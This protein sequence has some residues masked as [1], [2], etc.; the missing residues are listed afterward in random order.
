MRLDIA[1]T[2]IDR[3]SA[4]RLGSLTKDEIQFIADGMTPD[5]V[6]TFLFAKNVKIFGGINGYANDFFAKG[7]LERIAA[8][9]AG[10]DKEDTKRALREMLERML[11][12]ADL[13]AE[14]RSRIT[15][16]I[17]GVLGAAA[18]AAGGSRHRRKATRRRQTRRRR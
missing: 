14:N 9:P 13:S 1:L 17:A 12:Y 16:A 4:A 3:A 7:T 5:E 8:M 15:G 10:P 11:T 2:F 18:A 6:G